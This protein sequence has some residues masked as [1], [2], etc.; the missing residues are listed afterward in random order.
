MA[1]EKPGL[2]IPSRESLHDVGVAESTADAL[3]LI[4]LALLSGIRTIVGL[5]E[6]EACP[7]AR[8]APS[9]SIS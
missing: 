2:P 9:T 8:I 4:F 5:L 7:L 3:M 1:Y 6:I